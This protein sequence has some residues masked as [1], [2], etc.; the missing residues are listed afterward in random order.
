[1]LALGADGFLRINCGTRRGD[2]WGNSLGQK[3]V[4]KSRQIVLP[5]NFVA[6]L[7]RMA[8][9]GRVHQL[10][11]LFILAIGAGGDFVEPFAEMTFRNSAEFDKRVKKMIVASDSGRW[12]ESAHGES[13]DQVVIK[14]LVLQSIGGRNFSVLT[15]M[16]LWIVGGRKNRFSSGD[17]GGINAK[18][19]FRGVTNPRFGIEGTI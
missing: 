6:G 2:V 3:R 5:A 19:I 12:N 8:E 1:M 11:V 10:D 17:G 16:R 13:V 7:R 9:V 14:F 15:G 4:A 18:M